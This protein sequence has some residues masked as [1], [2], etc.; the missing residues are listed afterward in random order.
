MDRKPKIIFFVTEDWYFWSHRLPLAC[1]ARDNGFE[2]VV[3]TRVQKHGE[4]IRTEGFRVIPIRLR[5]KNKNPIAELL[6]F[7]EIVHIY[8]RERPDIVH[9]VSMQPVL[10]G[11][12]AARITGVPAIVNALAGLGY[13]FSSPHVKARLIR[14]FVKSA[15][16]VLLNSDRSR[17]IIQNPDDLRMLQ[18][19]GVVKARQLVLIRGAGVDMQKFL[20]QREKDAMPIVIMASRMLWDKGVKEFVDAATFLKDKGIKARFALVGDSDSGNPGAVPVSRLHEWHASGIVEWWGYRD[21]MVNVLGESS[22]VCLP[23]FYGEGIPKVL[24]EAAACGRPIVTTDMPGCREVVQHGK[25]G[26][27][28]PARDFMKLALALLRL[29]ENP[30]LRQEFGAKGR[31]IA[32]AEFSEERVVSDTLAVYKELLQR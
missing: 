11:T 16:L 14:V 5:R 20:P 9:H 30:T 19:R 17:V 3:A 24:I 15:F 27:L 22:I 10:Y 23:S 21:D 12:L 1:A 26:L 25:S 18:S 7:I 13:V 31:E 29:I 8:K 2:V 28:V 6:S 32:E 4:Q